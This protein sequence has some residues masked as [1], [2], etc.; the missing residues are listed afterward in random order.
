VPVVCA[1]V[2][3]FKVEVARLTRPELRERPLIV[4]DRLERG[5]ALAVDPGAYELGARPGMTLLQA[6]ACAR[7][8]AIAVDEP[9]R[10]AALWEE[11]LD[12]LDAASPLVEDA[13]PGVAF[14]EMRGIEGTPRAWLASARAAL[15]AVSAGAL[16]FRLGLA[17][18]KFVARA[19][20]LVADG[21]IV[22]PGAERAFVA[23]LPLHVLDFADYV[24]ERLSLLGVR[25][26]GDLTAL[27]H[28]PFVRRFGPEAARGHERAAGLDREPLVPRPRT[29]RVERSLFGEGTAEREEQVLFALRTLVARVADDVAL[30][31]KRCGYLRLSLECEDGETLELPTLLAQPTAQAA[32]MFDLLRARLE[33]T[34]LASPVCGLRL[35]A[36]RLEEGGTERSL[37]AGSDPDPEVVAVALARI[38]AALGP[39]SALRAR[40]TS[41]HRCETRYAYETF[42]ARGLVR[43]APHANAAQATSEEGTL[44]YRVLAPREVGVRLERGRPVAVG[45][46]A[47][48]EVAGPWRVDESWWA[49]ALD[50]GAL[51]YASDAYDVLLADG[52]LWRIVHEA[53]R[54]YVRGAYD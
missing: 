17:A 10:C 14:L 48:V 44:A 49:Q 41:G 39:G 47:V 34:V 28:G 8:A 16:P 33:G 9:A 20:A 53:Q 24:V 51:P 54:W 13:E 12:A 22:R 43:R 46:R 38:E 36:E 35:G 19:A 3:A 26:L 11:A 15:G 23:P 37:F 30:A 27:P 18:N 2:P 32:I 45:G 5:H 1:L 7:E 52:T 40:V 25:T 21:S 6:S 42:D 31:G 50:E 29:L 4:V